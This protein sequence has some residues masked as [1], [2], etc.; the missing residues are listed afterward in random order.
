VYNK[1]IGDR[2]MNFCWEVVENIDG[3]RNNTLFH[4]KEDAEDFITYK[5]KFNYV[6]FEHNSVKEVGYY[7]RLVLSCDDEVVTLI[8]RKRQIH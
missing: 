3:V 7:K 1:G 4:N 2:I 6:D 8:R 5:L